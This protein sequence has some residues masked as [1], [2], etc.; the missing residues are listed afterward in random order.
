ML[1]NSKI[2][3]IETLSKEG[4]AHGIERWGSLEK[5]WHALCAEVDILNRRVILLHPANKQS[6]K[7]TLRWMAEHG[8]EADLEL[9][10]RIK[11]DPP[12]SS[13][14]IE[15]FLAKTERRIS[16][17]VNAPNYVLRKGE[18]AY[19]RN[20]EAWERQYAGQYIAIHRGAVVDADQDKSQLIERLMAAQKEQGPFRAYIVK[21]DTPT[22]AFRGPSRRVKLQR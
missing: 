19:Q 6:F 9:L 21:V 10:Q 1:L 3:L 15:Q 7:A 22:L 14:D 20:K 5:E 16:E 4:K 8:I 11:N 12:Y 13:K 2:N 18:E 17:K